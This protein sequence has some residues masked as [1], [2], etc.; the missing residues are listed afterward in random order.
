M[1]KAYSASTPS[2]RSKAREMI[3]SWLYVSIVIGWMFSLAVLL[4]G[5]PVPLPPGYTNESRENLD[6]Q[7]TDL[8][9][10]GVKNREDVLLLLGEP[11]GV[12]PDESWLAYGSVYG[13]GGVLFLFC[14]GSGCMGAGSEKME[15]KR[16][17][18]TFDENGQLENADFVSQECWE[19]LFGMGSSG[20]RTPPCLQVNAPDNALK[21]AIGHEDIDAFKQGEKVLIPKDLQDFA[22]G[23]AELITPGWTTGASAA[24]TAG[25]HTEQN[26]ELHANEQWETLARVVLNDNYGDDLRWYFLGRSAEGLGLCD[27]ALLYYENSREKSQK[28]ASRCLGG[29]CGIDLPEALLDRL[30]AIEVM[31]KANKCIRPDD[32]QVESE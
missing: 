9:K 12:G 16:L 26:L 18:I 29:V 27:T 17:V 21:M 1:K 3:P 11:D 5:C 25:T 8:I 4:I 24:W 14:A 28:F 30:N 23:K 31:R 2:F 15:Y 10:T 7:V 13:K 20:D 22:I 19:G 6:E 32:I